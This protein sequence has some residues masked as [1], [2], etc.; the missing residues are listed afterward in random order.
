MCEPGRT[1]RP[2]GT[3]SGREDVV[4]AAGQQEALAHP[5]VSEVHLELVVLACK[6]ITQLDWLD[7]TYSTHVTDLKVLY[8]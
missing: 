4:G 2:G 3:Y 7:Y 8:S 5:R 6:T 1:S